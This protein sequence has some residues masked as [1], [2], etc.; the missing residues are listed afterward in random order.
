MMKLSRKVDEGPGPAGVSDRVSVQ[1]EA[2]E[3]LYQ[4]Q[5]D[6]EAPEVMGVSAWIGMDAQES[7]EH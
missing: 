7:K 4:L 3:G 5:R 6:T 2:E 1:G